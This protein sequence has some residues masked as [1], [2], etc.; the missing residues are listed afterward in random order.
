MVRSTETSAAMPISGTD[1]RRSASPVTGGE[2]RDE[3]RSRGGIASLRR[4]PRT[5]T[6]ASAATAGARTNPPMAPESPA[7]SPPATIVTSLDTAYQA[8]AKACHP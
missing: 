1:A 5:P 4:A 8:C 2:L 6:V 3:D 7:S